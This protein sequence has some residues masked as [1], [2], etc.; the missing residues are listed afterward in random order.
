[1]WLSCGLVA[2]RRC[3]SEFF[4]AIQRGSSPLPQPQPLP[5][6]L[7]QPQSLFLININPLSP[8]ILSPTCPHES[9][10]GPSYRSQGIA[11]FDIA[12]PCGGA[13]RGRPPP[14][15]RLFF[16]CFR[17]FSRFFRTSTLIFVRGLFFA[18]FL[19]PKRMFFN[20]KC[21]LLSLR[22]RAV[23]QFSLIYN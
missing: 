10:T 12:S 17:F 20:I 16:Q 11:D 15:C 8:P 3:Q 13:L 4:G 22:S 23:F 19:R 9:P 18:S 5:Q 2:L 6:P 21:A 14:L 1:M 7:L